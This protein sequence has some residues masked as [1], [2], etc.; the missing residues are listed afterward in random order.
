MAEASAVS[1][2]RQRAGR[3]GYRNIKIKKDC[4]W[5]GYYHVELVEPLAGVCISFFCSEE[6]LKGLLSQR[7]EKRK[8]NF[9]KKS[10]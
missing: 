2:F 1:A 10:L 8:N 3:L 5:T 6:K 9:E 7:A 4:F